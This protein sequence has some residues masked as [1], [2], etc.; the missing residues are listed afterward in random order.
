MVLEWVW[1]LGFG[2]EKQTR[3]VSKEEDLCCKCFC[4]HMYQKDTVVLQGKYT[5]KDKFTHYS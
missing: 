2:D 5:G 3:G 1:G 4:W